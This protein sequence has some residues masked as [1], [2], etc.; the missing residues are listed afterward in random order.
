MCYTNKSPGSLTN[1]AIAGFIGRYRLIHPVET[2]TFC[3]GEVMLLPDTPD[4]INQLTESGILVQVITNG[5]IDRIGE[6]K[7]P[8]LVNIIVS[9]DGISV[10][11]DLN[12]GE[13][14]FKKSFGFLKHAQ[15][16]GFHTGIFSIVTS[17][18]LPEIPEFENFLKDK[19]PEF[20]VITYHPRK[21][22]DYLKLHPV[23]NITGETSGFSFPEPE[24][25]R[26][27]ART[28]KVFPG[29]EL[30]CYQPSL[31]SDGKIY[32]CCEGF[33]PLGNINGDIEELISNFRKRIRR[34]QNIYPADKTLGCAEA[35][36]ICGLDRPEKRIGME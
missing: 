10:Y 30:G 22:R 24:K 35:D 17:E 18:N 9:L 11:H 27:L 7:T 25:I 23:S 26:R 16:A 12:R 6:I 2:V 15:L 3:G 8:N 28:K 33:T 29:P 21:S 5:T 34:W 31:M 1:A 36:F 13:G 19:L 4:L 32:A 20:P 14:M